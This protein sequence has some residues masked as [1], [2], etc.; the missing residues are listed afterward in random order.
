MEDEEKSIGRIVYEPRAENRGV[1]R[2]LHS[3]IRIERLYDFRMHFG[4]LQGHRVR[5]A[6]LERLSIQGYVREPSSIIISIQTVYE[7]KRGMSFLEIGG[8]GYRVESIGLGY[9]NGRER[10]YGEKHEERE[11]VGFGKEFHG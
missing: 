7:D 1:I 3:Q 4:N 5:K 9:G 10:D 2:L 11:S 6:G 8:I